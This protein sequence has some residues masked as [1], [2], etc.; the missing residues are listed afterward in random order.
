MQTKHT[1]K[2]A[3]YSQPPHKP[4]PSHDTSIQVHPRFPGGSQVHLQMSSRVPGSGQCLF[5]SCGGAMSQPA[6]GQQPARQQRKASRS[7]S[8][9][10]P[11]PRLRVR[12]VCLRLLLL[13][14]LL[15]LLALCTGL[16]VPRICMHL[17][18]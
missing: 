5:T 14:L 13:L 10:Q 3:H 12:C 6:M 15:L 11:A 4:Q 8:R 2:A 16:H 18:T 17:V 9:S 1:L 7:A